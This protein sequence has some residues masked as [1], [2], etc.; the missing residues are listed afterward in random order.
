MVKLVLLQKL[1]LG[2]C[3]IDRNAISS[4][5]G[6]YY[7]A[8]C[9]KMLSCFVI[10]SCS[11]TAARAAAWHNHEVVVGLQQRPAES[12]QCWQS[13]RPADFDGRRPTCHHR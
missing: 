12:L 1:T 2:G 4:G 8:V 7:S 13:N 9:F 10:G 3:T 11:T 5:E 6:S